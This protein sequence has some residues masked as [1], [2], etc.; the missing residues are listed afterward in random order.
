MKVGRNLPRIRRALV[1]T[2]KLARAVYVERGTMERTVTTP[3]AAK[4][5]DLAPYFSIVLVPGWEG[6]P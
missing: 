1:A 2:G 3:L 5:D 6:R 4:A